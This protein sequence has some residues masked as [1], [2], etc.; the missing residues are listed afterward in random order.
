MDSGT[1][2]SFAAPFVTGVVAQYVQANPTATPA[3]VSA[4]VVSSATTGVLSNIGGFSPNRLL[5]SQCNLTSSEREK[6]ARRAGFFLVL[7]SAAS[8]AS[9]R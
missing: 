3:Q 9:P 6:P 5:Y 2:T 4:W 1:G 7:R 8:S